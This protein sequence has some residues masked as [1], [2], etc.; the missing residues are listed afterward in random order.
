MKKKDFKTA[1]QSYE[2]AL[3]E[4]PDIPAQANMNLGHAYYQT[5]DFK[6]AQ[7]NYLSAA[8]N[9]NSSSLKS[10]AYQQIGNIYSSQKNYQAAAE[11]YKKS[12]K[13]NPENES[14]RFNYELAY[15][16]NRKQEENQNRQNP[17]KKDQNKKDQDQNKEKQNQKNPQDKNQ[18]DKGQDQKSSEKENKEDPKQGTPQNKKQGPQQGNKPGQEQPGESKS[19]SDKKQEGAKEENPDESGKDK[20]AKKNQESNM[21]DPDAQRMD[22]KKLQEAGL[23]E[24]Q[25]KSLLQAMRQNEVKYLQQRRFKSQKGGADKQGPKWWSAGSNQRPFSLQTGIDL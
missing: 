4:S 2:E 22:R 3:K 17:D 15:K 23:T 14:A 13:T 7:K 6:K 16:L 20:S 12:L 10:L 21:D 25:A 5:G 1:I 11:W 24:E 9:L 19:E 18:G 8:T